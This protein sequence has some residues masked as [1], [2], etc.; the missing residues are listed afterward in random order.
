VLDRDRATGALTPKPGSGGCVYWPHQFYH[1]SDCQRGRGLASTAGVAVSPDGKEVFVAAFG[2]AA[3][4]NDRSINAAALTVF[5]RDPATG[6]LQQ[7]PGQA[8]CVSANPRQRGCDHFLPIKSA[9]GVA[10]SPDG[11]SVYVAGISP[12]TLVTFNRGGGARASR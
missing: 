8:G 2:G 12:G 7:K 10:I 4:F 6:A 11:K 5:S 1:L 9:V 3:A